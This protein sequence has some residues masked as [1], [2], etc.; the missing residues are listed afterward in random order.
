[1]K[2][3]KLQTAIFYPARLSFRFDRE[4]KSF[5]EKQ[6]LREFITTKPVL[7]QILRKLF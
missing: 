2:G 3:K 5:P 6:N 7:L 4:I 1:M